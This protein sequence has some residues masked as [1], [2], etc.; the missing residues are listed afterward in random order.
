MRP[1]YLEMWAFGP[2]AQQAVVDFRLLGKE[3]LYLI[4][5][6]TGAGKTTIFDAI[7]FALYNIT[8]GGKRSGAMMRS[9]FA[10]ADMKTQVV[11]TFSYQD[12]IYQVSRSPEYLRPKKR[13]EGFL[14]EAAEATLILPEGQVIS[15]VRE[16]DKALVELMGIDKDQFVQTMMIAQGEF[17]RLILSGTKE[18]GEILRKIFAT[19]PYLTFQEETKAQMLN[20]RRQL[21]TENQKVLELASE[22]EWDRP[23]GKPGEASFT[24]HSPKDVNNLAEVSCDDGTSV[25]L[26]IEE[27]LVQWIEKQDPYDSGTL[28]LLG[29]ELCDKQRA[30]FE[31][32]RLKAE[33][34]AA[35]VSDLTVKLAVVEKNNATLKQLEEVELAWETCQEQKAKQELQEQVLTSAKLALYTIA[36]IEK[37]YKRVAAEAAVLATDIKLDLAQLEEQQSAFSALEQAY[38]E[39]KNLTDQRERLALEVRRLEEDILLYQQMEEKAQKIATIQDEKQQIE[40]EIMNFQGLL[41]EKKSMLQSLNLDLAGKRDL[42][43]ILERLQQR[44]REQTLMLNQLQ[45]AQRLYETWLH[46]QGLYEEKQQ[47]FIAQQNKWQEVNQRAQEVESSF[48]KEQA[49]VLASALEIGQPCPV[50]GSLEHPRLASLTHRGLTEATVKAVQ[51]ERNSSY[52]LLEQLSGEAKAAGEV[53]TLHGEAWTQA[54]EKLGV[55]LS[56]QDGGIR[57]LA[58]LVADKRKELILQEQH[59]QDHRDQLEQLDSLEQQIRQLEKNLEAETLILVKSQDRLSHITILLIQQQ[60]E[61]QS[62]RERL[63]YVDVASAKK[64]YEEMKTQL[65]LLQRDYEAARALCEEKSKEINQITAVLEEKQK[66]LPKLLDLAE[67]AKSIFDQALVQN[68]FVNYEAYQ[69]ALLNQ[70]EIQHLQEEC[71]HYQQ[72]RLLLFREKER[73]TLETVGKEWVDIKELLDLKAVCLEEQKIYNQSYGMWQ[74]VFD[75]NVRCLQRVKNIV[76]GREEKERRYLDYR[77]IANTA[78]GELPGKTKISFETYLQQAYF[79]RILWAANQRLSAMTNERYQLLTREVVKDLRSQ[80]G[81]ELDVL[82][83]YTGKVRDIRS[84]SGGEAFKSSLSLALGLADVVQQYSGGI[85]LEAMFIDEGF[86]SLDAESLEMAITTLQNLAGKNKLIGII[87]HV[88]TLKERIDK[89][90]IVKQ[91]KNGSKIEMS[92]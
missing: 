9:D 67:Q 66:Q 59:I 15:N 27:K 38:E 34:L 39:K 25:T 2:Y 37:D 46:S 85:Q 45:E 42:P 31:E 65:F 90:I 5:G 10:A 14:K 70:E 52:Q 11:F 32:S 41:D 80:S 36:P 22:F 88:E 44:F 68:N 6:D 12:N 86:G 91:G 79:K 64:N 47:I 17:L 72:K 16:V 43:L 62:L 77:L 84:L 4:T 33:Q 8:S 7:T 61:W 60:S 55:I 35:Q 74:S 49:G 78:N 13:G 92:W 81:L 3:G 51:K 21:D 24:D 19:A 76:V 87:S 28:L 50:C 73:L 48:L 30:L 53:S 1:L 63:K 82:D 89:Q 58:K 29:Q 26:S 18:R 20:A 23:L 71:D 69:D 56:E 40:A 57:I 75:H 54:V 83:N